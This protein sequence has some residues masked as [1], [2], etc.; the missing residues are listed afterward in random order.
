MKTTPRVPHGWQ[1]QPLS[2]VANIIGGGTPSTTDP[3]YW[4]GAIPWATPTDITA[5]TGRY[6]AQTEKTITDAGLSNSGA[7]LLPPQSLLM[8]S[9][10]TIGKCAINSI[11]MATNQ[12][13]A[14]LVC[15]NKLLVDYAYYLITSHCHELSRLA[16]GSTF[17]ELSKKA[18]QDFTVLVPPTEEQQK[19]ATI[20]ASVD[21][22]IERTQSLIA[23]LGRVKQALLINL[24]RTGLPGLHRNS[25][26]VDGLG[27]IPSDWQVARLD[28]VAEVSRGKFSH[29]P[30]NDPNYYGG[31]YPFV[32]TGDVTACTG[33]LTTHSQTLN[34]RGLA[35]SRMFPAETVL[36]T[37]AANIGETAIAGFPVAFPDSLVGVV[38][39]GEVSAQYIEYFLRV[40]KEKLSNQ[41]TESAQKNINLE[42]L[43]PLLIPIPNI[44][45]RNRIVDIL[46]AVEQYELHERRTSTQLSAA[47]TAL[48]SV[49]LVGKK[50][51]HIAAPQA[52]TA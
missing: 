23:Q 27:S 39:K 44:E 38:P 29:R 6:I 35:V 21:D 2:S 47:K 11:P 43:R 42:T 48:M 1:S 12:G 8:T 19:I 31:P 18:F 22:A 33:R 51:V 13:F 40:V 15:N 9:R 50:R 46:N 36:V 37:I 25:K 16:S 32:Q 30:R 3:A 45:E 20:L 24:Y 52:A 49:L 34:D 41:A 14:S 5:L 7:R 17:I 26:H 28:E 4:N 10:A